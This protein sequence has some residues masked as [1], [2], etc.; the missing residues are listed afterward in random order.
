MII[1]FNRIKIFLE[2]LLRGTDIF[3]NFGFKKKRSTAL[4]FLQTWEFLFSNPAEKKIKPQSIAKKASGI[5]VP[6]K[7]IESKFVK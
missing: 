7:I 3:L 1:G 4:F 6:L 5:L 2:N